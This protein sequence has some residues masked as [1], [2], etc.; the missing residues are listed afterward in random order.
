M[1]LTRINGLIDDPEGPAVGVWNRRRAAPCM[2]IKA[3]VNRERM[4]ATLTWGTARFA[5]ACGSHL[6]VDH[7]QVCGQG[8]PRHMLGLG[9][10]ECA[11]CDRRRLNTRVVTPVMAC[12]TGPPSAPTR[13]RSES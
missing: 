1:H 2:Q 12:A 11:T 7:R 10:H 4:S 13:T 5:I 6:R 3:T 8:Q 9:G